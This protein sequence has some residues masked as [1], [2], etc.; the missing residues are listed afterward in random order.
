MFYLQLSLLSSNGNCDLTYCS[1]CHPYEWRGCQYC[2]EIYCINCDYECLDQCSGEG[3]ER[4]NCNHGFC[5]DNN[6]E[7]TDCVRDCVLDDLGEEGC[8]VEYCLECRVKVCKNNGSDSCSVCLTTIA[9]H[10][11]KEKN[12]LLKMLLK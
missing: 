10:L 8:L 6:E 3:C 5:I 12:R 9:P 11:G 7:R 1:D 4:T 2:D